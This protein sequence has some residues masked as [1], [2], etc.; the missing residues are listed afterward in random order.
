MANARTLAGA[1]TRKKLTGGQVPPKS[2]L[3]AKINL[4]DDE[5]DPGKKEKPAQR[6]FGVATR[7]GE[8]ETNDF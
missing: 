7:A 2:P 8:I 4:A 6:K 1:R 5:L 3:I